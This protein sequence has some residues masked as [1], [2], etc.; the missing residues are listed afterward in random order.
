MAKTQPIGVR[1]D[2]DLLRKLKEDRG[3]ETAQQALNFLS[4]FWVKN[5]PTQKQ[6]NDIIAPVADLLPRSKKSAI[7]EDKHP[8]G[9]TG[10]DLTIWKAEQ[11]AKS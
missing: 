1:F 5:D 6:I 7:N 4:E 3:I 9:L 11:K 8:I 2:T 10:I